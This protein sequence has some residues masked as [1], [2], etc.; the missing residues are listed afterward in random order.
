MLESQ[1]LENVHLWYMHFLHEMQSKMKRNDPN[2]KVMETLV[3]KVSEKTQCSIMPTTT[4]WLNV[5]LPVSSLVACLVYIMTRKEVL[6]L[7]RLALL[8]I[9]VGATF[10]FAGMSTAPFLDKVAAV[11]EK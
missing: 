2:Y 1:E 7:P 10:A 11:K 3:D 6:S 8:F 4:N 9:I 5:I